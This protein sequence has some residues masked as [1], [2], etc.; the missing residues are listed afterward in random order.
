MLID[1]AS[2][3]LLEETAQAITTLAQDIN[4]A[5][6]SQEIDKMIELPELREALRGCA[7][8]SVAASAKTLQNIQVYGPTML[9]EEAHK[10]AI[11]AAVKVCAVAQLYCCVAPHESFYKVLHIFF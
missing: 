7:R 5:V 10:E 11:M 6:N 1:G 2:R 8:A 4:T 3:S 9:M